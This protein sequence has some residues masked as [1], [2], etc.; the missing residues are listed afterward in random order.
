MLGFRT[1]FP[2]NF[3]RPVARGATEEEA[4]AHLARVC[5]LIEER[6][7]AL[8]YGR[9]D[10]SM[11]VIVGRLLQERGQTVAV[12]ESCTGGLLGERITSVPGSSEWFLGGV[13][14]YSN[15]VKHEM[16]G[17]PEAMLAEHGAV[18]EPRGA[19]HGRRCTR[20]ARGDLGALDHG[21]LGAGRW[22]RRETGR[23]GLGRARG[24][25]TAA[26]P[27]SASSSSIV[28]EIAR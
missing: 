18:S 8:V 27:S 24:A 12:A 17:V 13:Q 6:L 5:E 19:R 7:G 11:E 16:L 25:P 3:L 20:S 1:T 4:N 22:H 9:D 21:D 10:E 15:R 2:D 28:S 14:A 23:H 26:R